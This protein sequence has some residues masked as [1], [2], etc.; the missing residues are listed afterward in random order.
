MYICFDLQV[1]ALQPRND[2]IQQRVIFFQGEN[3]NSFSPFKI[4]AR[5]EDASL[6][7]SLCKY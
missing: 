6:K 2:E 1:S 7:D 4:W 5:F 3:R